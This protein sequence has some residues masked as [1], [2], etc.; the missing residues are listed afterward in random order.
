[1]LNVW[2]E[3]ADGTF[4][5]IVAHN[6]AGI[7]WH[8][9]GRALAQSPPV[10]FGEMKQIAF[11][12]GMTLY[13]DQAC[14]TSYWSRTPRLRSGAAGLWSYTAPLWTSLR[15]AVTGCPCRVGRQW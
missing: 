11:F 12:P 2:Y 6:Q 15:T 4:A 8:P 7:E 3:R 14:P 10:T 13:P 5:W 9:D 1:M